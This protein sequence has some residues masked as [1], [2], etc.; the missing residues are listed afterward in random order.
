MVDESI[1]F[2]GQNQLH[3]EGLGILQSIVA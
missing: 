2:E 3:F 1:V